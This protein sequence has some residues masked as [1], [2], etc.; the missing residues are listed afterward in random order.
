MVGATRVG[1][2]ALK[3]YEHSLS[4]TFFL[5]FVVAITLHAVSGASDYSEEQV[6]ATSGTPVRHP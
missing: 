5:F 3:L 1:F 6:G 2:P 4:L